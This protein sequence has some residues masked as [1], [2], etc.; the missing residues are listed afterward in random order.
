MDNVVKID[1]E[2]TGGGMRP[3]A[4][5]NELTLGD[6][7]ELRTWENTGSTEAFPCLKRLS[8]MKSAADRR[9]LLTLVIDSIL[10]LAFIPKV[11]VENCLLLVSLTVMSCPKLHILPTNLGRIT[12]LKSL[13]IGW[14]EML[15]SL[16][17]GFAD[18]ISLENLEIIEC[19]TLITL[20]EQSLNRLSSLRSLSIEN[21]HGLTSLPRGM[22]HAT[23]LERL[24]VIYCSN[25]ASLPDG[26]HNLLVLKSLTVL[27]C[28]E[29]SSLPEGVQH[30]KMLQNLEI[31]TCPK[32]ITLPEKALSNLVNFNT[33]PFKT[34]LNLKN[35]AKGEKVRTG[36]RYLTSHMFILEHQ[37]FKTE[38]ALQ[39]APQVHG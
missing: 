34:V 19:P 25:L 27:N 17:H 18:L 21:C 16:P 37:Y 33:S 36:Q 2:F 8:I 32:L 26:L 29:L 11:L 30:M 15:D 28:P 22:Q 5:L 6:I 9:T 38:K 1:N 12:A 4:S 3:F 20:P 23:A 7:P 31:R 39:P 14:C 35:D 13:K 10:E 24:T